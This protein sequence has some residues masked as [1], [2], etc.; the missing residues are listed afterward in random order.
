MALLKLG[1][2]AILNFAEGST[3]AQL[4]QVF[5]QPAV[6]HVLK[7]GHW[8]FARRR[9]ALAEL[10]PVPTFEWGH[11]YALPT[12]P[13]CLQA[14]R[15]V[16]GFPSTALP[17]QFLF[18]DLIN[19]VEIPWAIE[20]RELL[21]DVA[22]AYLVYTARI[23]DTS[24][25]TGDFVGCLAEYLAAELAYAVTGNANTQQARYQMYEQKLAEAKHNNGRE[26]TPPRYK[27]N[28]V[29]RDVRRGY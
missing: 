22:P 9:A 12:D 24:Q 25:F 4:C 21:T 28:G 29:F 13:Y 19:T 16:D 20:G 23:T 18:D 7:Q 3:R 8:K 5:Y 2:D 15:L 26:G 14:V 27:L 11:R 10:L 17:A 6:E 1:D